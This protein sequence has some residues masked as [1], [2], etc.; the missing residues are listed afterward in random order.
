MRL[1]MKSNMELFIIITII[2]IIINFILYMYVRRVGV[3]AAAESLWL[4]SHGYFPS[5]S[6]LL[7]FSLYA[8][9]CVL[10]FLTEQARI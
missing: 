10:V 1:V 5:P 7:F 2:T 6:L 9:V 4:G 8:S 3:R